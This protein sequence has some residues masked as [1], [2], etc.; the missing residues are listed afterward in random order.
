[1]NIPIPSNLFTFDTRWFEKVGL[2]GDNLDSAENHTNIDTEDEVVVQSEVPGRIGN[3]Q[4]EDKALVLAPPRKILRAL[5][6]KLALEQSGQFIVGSSLDSDV[7][8]IIRDPLRVL[9]YETKNE[10][11]YSKKPSSS[12]HRETFS[13][14]SSAFLEGTRKRQVHLFKTE[15]SDESTSSQKDEVLHKNNN[16]ASV[17]DGLITFL[18]F[19]WH[20]I[21]EYERF[22][23]N[24][25]LLPAYKHTILRHQSSSKNKL[26]EEEILKFHSDASF[27]E[28][29][30]FEESTE[31]CDSKDM[32]AKHQRCIVSI[33]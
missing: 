13:K 24:H 12:F 30:Y 26:E 21:G 32:E 11:D 15:N 22:L 9:P 6:D 4:D 29:T 23:Q 16:K 28:E 27:T 33:I 31:P 1:M 14:I 3:F 5:E 25:N 19:L 18:Q 8:D 10:K 17:I 7:P 20:C 2:V